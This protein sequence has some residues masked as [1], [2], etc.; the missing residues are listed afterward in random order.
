LVSASDAE[1]YDLDMDY[2]NDTAI[3]AQ[4]INTDT[5]LISTYYFDY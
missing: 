5:N 2:N 3:Y 1:D 4:C